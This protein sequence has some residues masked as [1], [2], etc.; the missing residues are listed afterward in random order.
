MAEFLNL[1]L[2]QVL[3]QKD[4]ASEG[5]FALFQNIELIADRI[6]V[7]E[8]QSLTAGF[9]SDFSRQ[10]GSEMSFDLFLIWK[11]AFQNEKIH[12]IREVDNILAII[13][14]TGYGNRFS[15]SQ[16]NSVSN[17]FGDMGHRL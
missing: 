3:G 12:S 8:Q 4:L 5:L 13:G 11:G 16:L 9:G 6:K 14:V 17:A 15:V 7:C 10:R 2:H 1:D